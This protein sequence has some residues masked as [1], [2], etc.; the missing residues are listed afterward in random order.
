[1]NHT[2]ADQAV[3][4]H[5]YPLGLCAAPKQNDFQ[6]P[7]VERLDQ[8]V[9]W[10]DHIQGLGCTALYLGPLFESS[11][12]GYDTA[13]YYQVD[14]RLGT[15]DTLSRFS[16]ELHYRGLKLV[17]DGVFNHTGRDFWAFKDLQVN[18]E[19]S[20]YA[21]WF[22]GVDFSRSSPYNDP[23]SYDGW[24]GHYD[25]VKLNLDHPD[26]RSHL[27]DAVRLW[28]EEFDIDGLRLDAADQ[29]SPGFLSSLARFCR[30]LRPEFWLMGEMVG[31]DYR[32]LANSEML[33]SVTNYEAYKSLYSS[34]VDK[35]YFEIAYSLNRQF[36]AGGIYREFQPYNFADNH[37][38]NRVA[39][40]LKDPAH[41]YPLYCLLFSMPGIPSIYY[42]SEWGLSGQR[43]PSSDDGLRPQINLMEKTSF[44]NHGLA[45]TI[46]RLAEVHRT[47]KALT[48]G[49]YVQLHVSSEQF[50]FLRS[51]PEGDM[52]TAV[53]SSERPCQLE[54]QL[55]FDNGFLQDLLDPGQVFPIAAD[56]ASIFVAASGGRILSVRR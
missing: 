24:S 43:T 32:R 29:M 3:F 45:S 40:S 9:P 16:R 19:R 10:L 39:S 41:L 23:F 6:S 53:N 27:F 52:I 47:K 1:M 56:R 8:L 37:D 2:W 55:P 17:L 46:T 25:L 49:N 13:D 20:A 36:G 33:D 42:G 31:G 38:V 4:Y 26:V 34:H 50:A 11:V 22:Q 18:R 30:D 28:I 12:H 5:I 51:H 54:L 44:P 14:R 48:E 21:G 7:T 15:R 35:N